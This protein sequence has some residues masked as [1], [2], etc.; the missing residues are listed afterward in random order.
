MTT[1]RDAFENATADEPPFRV[2]LGTV[3]TDGWRGRRRRQIT[4]A[5]ASAVAVAVVAAGTVAVVAHRSG[6][7]ATLT[8][9]PFHVQG[10]QMRSS[11]DGEADLTQRQ[12]RV[13]AAVVAASPA[14]W[15]FDFGA[16]HWDGVSLE[17]T[18][19]DGDAPGRLTVGVSPSP[20]TQQVHP[21]EDPEF[22]A[23]AGCSERILADGAVL[24]LRD[25]VESHGGHYVAAVLT[26]PDG[27]GVGAESGNYV[28]TWPLP[29]VVTP[30]QKRDLVHVSPNGT[31]YT[32]QQL[33]DVVLAV[34]RAL[35]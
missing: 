20:G 12:S 3:M 17:T 24:S 4:V 32:V 28:L 22:R 15:T 29:E 23:G 1:L 35:R 25:S 16:D 27:S 10:L 31:V 33:A 19:D 13:A 26:Y 34:N 21:C 11:G 18:A 8:V 5:T 2:S 6:P 30:E 7:S 9:R 14:G